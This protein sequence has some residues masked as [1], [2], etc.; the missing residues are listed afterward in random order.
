MLWHLF[1]SYSSRT[2]TVFDD[3]AHQ[4]LDCLTVCRCNFS[5]DSKAATEPTV[6]NK[7]GKL[8]AIENKPVSNSIALSKIRT[9]S[10]PLAFEKVHRSISSATFRQCTAF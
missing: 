7:A 10:A 6:Q 2:C 8:S 9:S 5:T 3:G 4:S 1:T